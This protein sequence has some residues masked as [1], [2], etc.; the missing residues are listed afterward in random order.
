MGDL[1]D[2]DLLI[3]TLLV[4]ASRETENPEHRWETASD[5]D[6]DSFDLVP[7]VTHSSVIAQDR[8]GRGAWTVTLTVSAYLEGDNAQAILTRLYR[9]IHQWAESMARVDGV[10]GITEVEDLQA[11]AAQSGVVPMQ[12]KL[13][14]HY[15]GQFTL[16]AQYLSPTA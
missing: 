11:F 10:G 14:R 12:N 4:R 5:L 2:I 13:V 1:L 7:F 3:N 16:L 8:N 6:V 15:A 9:V